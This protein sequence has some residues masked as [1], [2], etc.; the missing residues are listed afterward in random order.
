[1]NQNDWHSTQNEDYLSLC[2]T[3][4]TEPP[5]EWC[6]QFATIIDR[7]FGTGRI[8]DN[9]TIKDIRCNV[10]HFARV[11]SNIHIP[12]FKYLG[13]DISETY[14]EIARVSFPELSFLNVDFSSK[15]L[16]FKE[17]NSDITIISATFEHIHDYKIALSNIVESMRRLIV[18][19][20]FIGNEFKQEYCSK[21]GAVDSYL[22]SQ[23]KY[24]QIAD[25]AASN[26]FRIETEI[27][28]ATLGTPKII[29]ESPRII[30]FQQV[31]VLAK[32]QP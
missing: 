24:Q 11:L 6:N 2:K 8:T 27:D 14:L 22:I 17:L 19:R 28:L 15:S 10:G 20:T 7:E 1:M 23:F 3:R 26:G 25:V 5:L 21:P 16:D 29:C 30:R 31:L 13:I 4:L 12:K 18:I 9:V 32:V